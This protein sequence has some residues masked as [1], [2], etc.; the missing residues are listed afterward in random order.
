MDFD[1]E[2]EKYALQNAFKHEGKA[3]PGPVIGQM[4]GKHHELQGK[5]NELMPSIAKIV[6]AVNK[7]KPEQQR[8]KLQQIAPELLEEKHER[9]EIGLDELPGAVMDKVVTRTAPNPNGALHIGNA[10]AAVLSFLYAQKYNG[11]F[12][13][14]YD[15][16]SPETKPPLK[17]AYGWIE[18]D[19]RWL[20]AKIDM[21][22]YASKNF[23][24]YYQVIEQ[25]LKI[26]KAYV[27]MCDNDKWK[28]KKKKGIAC[29]CRDL[30]PAEH[31]RRWQHMLTDYKE[32][33]AV[34]R[35]KTDLEHKDP[36]RRD[37]WAAKI[38]AKPNH[39]ISGNKYRVWPS[40]NLQSAIDDHDHGVTHIIRGQEHT[41]NEMRQRYIYDYL[42]WQYPVALHHGRIILETGGLSA[43]KSKTNAAIA[44]GE[45]SGWDDP[46][47]IT[48]RALR[49]RGFQPEAIRDIEVSIGLNTNDTHISRDMMAAANR[50]YIDKTSNRYMFVQNPVKIV[51]DKA[52]AIE[53]NLK[54][55]PDYPER[56]TRKVS[57]NGQFYIPEND[58]KLLKTGKLYRLMDCLNFSK[59]RGKFVYKSRTIDEYRQG[60][61][62]IMHWVATSD[63]VPVEVLMIDGST[64]KGLGESS[65]KS[66]NVGDIV[67]FNR[68]AFCRLEKKDS[69]LVFVYTHD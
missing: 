54:N 21:V 40:Y 53:S 63:A 13:L 20:G 4:M 30:E 32:E 16:T 59:S 47:L 8:A 19:L 37:W 66:L 18:E 3:S 61:E 29:A 25:L 41:Q 50:K 43:S 35:I 69:T 23:E 22:A 65:L 55:H 12:I 38:I 27:C 11:K 6:A 42:G 45:F 51:I 46:R 68:F 64:A 2:I 5:V 39:P 15:D 28:E 34:L 1:S 7:L 31:L 44:S 26:G 24:R 56:G 52:P 67:Q 58:F 57:T 60:G 10:R 49:R 62:R 17:E 33:E 14:R 48:I 9:R 36:S